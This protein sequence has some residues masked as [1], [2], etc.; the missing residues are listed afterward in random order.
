VANLAYE[1]RVH[2]RFTVD[3]WQTVGE[4]A[5]AYASTILDT[6]DDRFVFAIALSDM[7]GLVHKSFILCLR[8]CVRGLEFW[9]NNDGSNF[10]V[11][12]CRRAPEPTTSRRA[13]EEGRSLIS[14]SAPSTPRPAPCKDAM[15]APLLLQGRDHRRSQLGAFA[16]V[17]RSRQLHMAAMLIPIVRSGGGFLG[18]YSLD[19]QLNASRM[20][21]SVNF[22]KVAITA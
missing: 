16:E 18:R 14:F 20:V 17:E 4:V 10:R 15:D 9:D 11:E 13:I 7:V 6:D 5:G 19:V 8:Y 21:A 3:D 1:K 2:C 22:I 12:F